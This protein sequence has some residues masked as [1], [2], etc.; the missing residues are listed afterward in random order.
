MHLD[1][2]GEDN[3]PIPDSTDNVVPVTEENQIQE[4]QNTYRWHI[5]HMESLLCGIIAS[6]SSCRLE[7]WQ[8]VSVDEL[9]ALL[10]NAANVAKHFSVNEFKIISLTDGYHQESLHL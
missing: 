10:F 8:G 5:D 2:N 6:S 3:E 4:A 9:I 7:R 1:N